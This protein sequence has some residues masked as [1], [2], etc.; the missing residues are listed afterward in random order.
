MSNIPYRGKQPIDGDVIKTT[1]ED[2]GQP[3][4]TSAFEQSL[5]MDFIVGDTN[6]PSWEGFVSTSN[7]GPFTSSTFTTG[8]QVDEK[9]LQAGVT[10]EAGYQ[11][12]M[13][14]DLYLGL[15][16]EVAFAG[17]LNIGGHT[18]QSGEI[19]NP[20]SSFQTQTGSGLP[21]SEEFS[22]DTSSSLV[23]SD[24]EVSS[25]RRNLW[26]D[27]PTPGSVAPLVYCTLER[28]SRWLRE[29][30]P[31][32]PQETAERLKLREVRAQYEGKRRLYT[33]IR[34]AANDSDTT[35][36]VPPKFCF[37]CFEAVGVFYPPRKRMEDAACI[38]EFITKPERIRRGLPTSREY[39]PSQKYDSQQQFG[40]IPRQYTS[41]RI[42][43]SHETPM[44]ST[45]SSE[46]ESPASSNPSSSGLSVSRRS[47]GAH[48]DS[49][50]PT[51]GKISASSRSTARKILEAP[52][53]A[54]SDP[55]VEG[56]NAGD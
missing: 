10:P 6:H 23:P 29:R 27:I 41:K 17:P 22:G 51:R 28:F 56:P 40:L 19:E 3:N 5:D 1:G 12:T 42:S 45:R 15:S 49:L 35:D 52:R 2:S 53:Y 43:T 11:Q 38:C 18:R 7:F 50:A 31:Y 24:I 25:G 44:G 30:E 13:I 16:S 37:L 55:L 8:N 34:W 36:E 4:D 26:K 48:C 14:S 46:T 54:K 32:L 9:S 39:A 20:N 47:R 33:F 21:V